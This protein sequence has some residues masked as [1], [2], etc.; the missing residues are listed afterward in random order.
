MQLINEMKLEFMSKSNNEAFGRIVAA[1]FASQLDPTVEEL[2]D[3]KTAVSEAVT[4][5]IIHGYEN[6]SGMVRMV[7]RLY[8][9]GIEIVISDE[10][11]GI[12]DV[13]LARQPLY[14]SK[15]DMER[16]GMGFT[17]MES[18]M[19]RVDIVSEPDKGTTV[20]LFKNIK[21]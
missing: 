7:C 4:N 15:P 21:S 19:D 20:T 9:D 1:A 6:N 17:V 8:D 18:F 13:E 10:G 14:T 11:K 16:S 3:I 5:A 12:E 2:A